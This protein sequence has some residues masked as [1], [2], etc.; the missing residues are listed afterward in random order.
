MRSLLDVPAPAKLNLFLHV[1]GRRADG[2]H[3]LQS[4][5]MLID[6]CDT[7]HFEQRAGARLSR[8]DL[9]VPLPADDLVLRAAR[10]LQAATGCTEGAH[11]A[12]DKRIPAQA[13]MGGGSSDA[14]T[15]LLALNRLWKLGLDAQALQRIGL[16]LGADV[17]FFLFGRNAWAE[18]VGEAL[19]PLTLP[20]ARFVVLKPPGGLNT[21][22]I[23]SDPLLQCATKPA[24]ISFFA[25][26]PYGFG[27][28]DL[29]PV[30]E[31]YDPQIAQGI[32]FLRSRGLSARMTGSGNA[33]FA[34]LPDGWLGSLSG[35]LGEGWQM[36]E[37]GNMEI[38]PLCGWVS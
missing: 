2:Y 11:I 33:I 4:A 26:D 15:T 28:N 36:R 3:L 35:G 12:I 6:W 16:S 37:C 18:G 23:F 17:P 5:F 38:H 24:T 13:G 22:E 27:R 1:T 34:L 14:A 10:A 25:A 29:Q 20:P 31:R 21:G 7:L 32:H 9:T 30:A 8:E 19:Q